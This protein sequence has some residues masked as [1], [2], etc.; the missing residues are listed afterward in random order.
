MAKIILVS[1]HVNAT[2]W[3]L[4]QALKAQQHEV[5]LLTSYGE[6]PRDTSGIE[7]MGYF[8]KWSFL[9]GVRII[10][11]L[12]GLQ[13]QILHVLLDDDKM[14]A[15]QMVLSTFAKS[16]PTCVLT[17]SLLNIKNGLSRRNPVRYLVE[18]S[19]IITCPTVETLGQLRGLD[20]RSNRQ[21]RGILP[22]VLDLK[23]EQNDEA[24]DSSELPLIANLKKSPYVVLPFNET[25]FN[26][27]SD[28]FLRLRAVAQ[29]YKVALWGTYA[30]WTLRDRKRFAAWMAEFQCADRWVLTGPLSAPVT[31]QLLSG[32]TALMLAG[33]N[34]TPVEMTEYYLRAIQSHAVLILDTRQTSVHS[35]LWKNTINC[36]VLNHSQLQK[37]LIKLLSKSHL[38]LPESLSEKL[39]EDRHLIDSS[40]NELNRL[41]NKA[42]NHLR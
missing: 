30:H 40:M 7:F 34:F 28:Y 35:D 27:D 5:V 9:E 8:K 13:P 3:Q 22:P 6:T 1:K 20:V 16:H 24:I 15:A 42:L 19:D 4:A 21:G 17:T 18:E 32:S 10:P 36:W 26:P 29:K 23:T 12:F 33:Q 39:A 41:Y 31:Q 2:S 14:N 38:R 37:D 11:G 25:R